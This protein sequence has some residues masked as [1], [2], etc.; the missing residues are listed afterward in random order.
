MIVVVDSGVMQVLAVS[1]GFACAALLIAV[2]R[3]LWD[4]IPKHITTVSSRRVLDAM[5]VLVTRYVLLRVL[6]AVL[7]GST[8][9]W[10]NE[11]PNR[12]FRGYCENHSFAEQKMCL[13]PDGTI[14]HI[15]PRTKIHI[16]YN[17]FYRNI[18]FDD[19]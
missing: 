10:V 17:I 5:G 19:K 6:G 12:F 9:F 13:L 16:D 1:L 8:A 7:F 3:G 14:A 11:Q 18:T 2:I 4:R 15:A